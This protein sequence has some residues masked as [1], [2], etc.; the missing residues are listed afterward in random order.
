MT[1]HARSPPTYAVLTNLKIIQLPC[2]KQVKMKVNA[3]SIE[4]GIDENAIEQEVTNYEEFVKIQQQ[5]KKPKP[6]KARVLIFGE[7]NV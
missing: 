1:V 7:T 4:C 2:E 6:M 5:K 3:D